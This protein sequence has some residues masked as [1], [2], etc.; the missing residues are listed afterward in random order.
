MLANRYHNSV[1]KRLLD[2]VMSILFLA[3]TSPLFLLITII[4][5]LTSPGP[6]FFIQKRAGKE[7]KPFG[8]IKFRTMIVGAEKFRKRY[9]KLN[10]SDGPVF[11]I[12]NDPRFTAFGKILSN[13]GLDEL[14]QFLNVLKSDMSIV[15]PR[16]LPVA[17]AK[18][19]TK[20]D[21]VRFLVKPGITSS[22]VV[23]GSHKL[24]FRKWMELDR[25]YVKKA[26]LSTDIEIIIRT[27]V[28][29]LRFL[30]EALHIT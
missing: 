14:P 7:G 6:V 21:A 15:G 23:N 8:I 27:F 25:Q 1:Q 10:E 16:P 19:I 2:A 18:R 4:S 22:W 11:K 28:M 9:E 17:E 30:T 20:K 13:T 5:V 24:K 29:M 12:K 3:M 26:D